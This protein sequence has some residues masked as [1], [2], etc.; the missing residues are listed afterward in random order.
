MSRTQNA[1]TSSVTRPDYAD[2]DWLSQPW[3]DVVGDCLMQIWIEW[4]TRRAIALNASALE[5]FS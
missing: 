5:E 3:P 2:N 4:I 1:L